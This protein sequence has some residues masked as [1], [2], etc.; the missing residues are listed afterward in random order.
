MPLG[1]PVLSVEQTQELHEFAIKHKRVMSVPGKSTGADMFEPQHLMFSP[2]TGRFLG[3]FGDETVDDVSVWTHDARTWELISQNAGI[4][5]KPAVSLNEPIDFVYQRVYESNKNSMGTLRF[6]TEVNH[7]ED[8]PYYA[9]NA[10]GDILISLP[11]NQRWQVVRPGM[12]PAKA[13]LPDGTK[14]LMRWRKI[15]MAGRLAI[16]S[17]VVPL[18]KPLKP[19]VW[20][21]SSLPQIGDTV[22]A[23]I[24]ERVMS[25]V[26][27]GY[28]P[29]YADRIVLDYTESDVIFDSEGRAAAFTMHSEGK[30]SFSYG[31]NGADTTVRYLRKLMPGIRLSVDS[32]TRTEPSHPIIAKLPH[33]I[34]NWG[35]LQPFLVPYNNIICSVVCIDESG[36]FVTPYSGYYDDGKTTH[37]RPDS[38]PQQIRSYRKRTDF[39]SAIVDEKGQIGNLSLVF[40]SE[41]LG[42][43]IGKMRKPSLRPLKAID[44]TAC[45]PPSPG[46]ELYTVDASLA[47]GKMMQLFIRH[48]VLQPAQYPFNATIDRNDDQGA[49]CYSLDGQPRGYVTETAPSKASSPLMLVDLAEIAKKLALVKEALGDR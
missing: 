3:W 22:Y 47:N 26:V 16:L 33:D 30:D 20:R 19:V 8:T 6:E 15:D 32:E 2:L 7:Y 46:E 29:S 49:L 31:Y 5:L 44:L 38:T 27:D 1:Q 36:Y 9:L 14:C 18:K 41:K 40:F 13:T 11:L 25:E 10:S 42:L 43:S 23:C 28:D 39:D 37:P 48:T 34:R 24:P 45:Q 21:T 35:Y 17:P 4:Q 12:E